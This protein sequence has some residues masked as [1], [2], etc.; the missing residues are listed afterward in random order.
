MTSRLAILPAGGLAI[1][2]ASGLGL[3]SNGGGLGRRGLDFS[4]DPDRCYRWVQYSAGDEG[5]AGQ[6]QRRRR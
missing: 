5:E 2:F 4:A 1:F 3:A 6:D